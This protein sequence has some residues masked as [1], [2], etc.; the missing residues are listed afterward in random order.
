MACHVTVYKISWFDRI[1]VFS[2]ADWIHGNVQ[3][4]KPL[5]ASS[6]QLL[7]S[8][9]RQLCK[10]MEFV[11][12]NIVF[13]ATLPSKL[14]AMASNLLAIPAAKFRLFSAGHRTP[15]PAPLTLRT[16]LQY[17]LQPEGHICG[18]GEVAL[19]AARA[20]GEFSLS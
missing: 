18:R 16:A 2:W 4:R 8:T 20:A 15:T 14:I 10:E 9:V 17:L 19:G 3:A 6:S 12:W 7:A 1:L 11:L 5:E 13:N